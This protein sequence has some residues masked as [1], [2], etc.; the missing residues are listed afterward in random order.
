MPRMKKPTK[1]PEWDEFQQ[2]DRPEFSDDGTVYGRVERYRE[3]WQATFDQ[4]PAG[5]GAT[6]EEAKRKVENAYERWLERGKG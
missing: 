2:P 4:K 6:K 5:L 3:A 1:R